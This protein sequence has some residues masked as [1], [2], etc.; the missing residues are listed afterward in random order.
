AGD[1]G[2]AGVVDVRADRELGL[3]DGEWLAGAVGRD[4]VAVPDVMGFEGVGAGRQRALAGGWV[5]DA[6][7]IQRHCAC[8][9]RRARGAV[10]AGVKGELDVARRRE[11][12]RA[13]VD[14]R[15]VV[16]G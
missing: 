9:S 1:D 16:Y 14:C 11:A 10:A 15:L 5:R 3:V 12:A 8:G 4:E 2:V 7:A 6:A 13:G